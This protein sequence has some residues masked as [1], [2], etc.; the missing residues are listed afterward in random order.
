M[1]KK[2]FEVRTNLIDSDGNEHINY[3]SHN[4]I[5]TG[6]ETAITKLLKSDRIVK[7][8]FALEVKLLGYIEIK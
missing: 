8:E 2:L 6:A 3:S 4:V 7:G 5:S 1:E